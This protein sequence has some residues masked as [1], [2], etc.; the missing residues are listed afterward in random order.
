[1]R[2][3]WGR[4]NAS[5]GRPGR[6]RTARG[7]RG[8]YVRLETDGVAARLEG[9]ARRAR[10]KG[11]RACRLLRHCARPDRARTLGL[12]PRMCRQS[13]LPVGRPSITATAVP[14][15]PLRR[16]PQPMAA[17]LK[18]SRSVRCSSSPRIAVILLLSSM[19]SSPRSAVQRLILHA[20][21]RLRHAGPFAEQTPRELLSAP[22]RVPLHGRRVRG[23]S[24]LAP[25]AAPSSMGSSARWPEP[26]FVCCVAVS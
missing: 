26:C 25:R 22:R 24:A 11:S 10:A 15:P 6:R 17:M 8:G 12:M 1:M 2:G 9:L 19:P 13:M 3:Y 16:H 7:G 23:E 14:P 4:I 21:T 18:S 20:M 5:G